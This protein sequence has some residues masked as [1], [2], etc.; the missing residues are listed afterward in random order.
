MD[1]QF[2]RNE[3]TTNGFSSK[4]VLDS[5]QRPISRQRFSLS[6]DAV[7][8][9]GRGLSCDVIVD[10]AFVAERHVALQLNSQGQLVL[11]DLGTINGVIVN[12]NRTHNARAVVTYKYHCCNSDARK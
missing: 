1:L 11:S 9:I 2:D 5:H 8:H 10:D 4:Y 12:G 6:G 3:L 7:I